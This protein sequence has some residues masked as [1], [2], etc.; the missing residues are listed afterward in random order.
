MPEGFRRM[1][2]LVFVLVF[3]A[4]AASGPA[5]AQE[6]SADHRR[7][8]EEEV[9]YIVTERER[10]VFLTL[11]TTDERDRFIEA[12]WRKRDPIPGT[13]ANEFREEHYRRLEHANRELR[14]EAFSPGWRTDRGRMH[15]VLGPP[16]SIE[17]F[18][19]YNQL[20]TSQLWFYHGDPQRNLPSFFYL[21]F[22]KRQDAVQYRL[23]IPGADVPGDLLRGPARSFPEQNMEQ[24]VRIS[25]ELARAALA[26]DASEAVDI[27]GGA[28]GLGSDAAIARIEASPKFA[29]RTDYLDAWE[30]YGRRVSSE[31]SF[32]FVPSTSSFAVLSGPDGASYLHLSLEL[33]LEDLPMD[34]S[35]DGSRWFTT[36]DAS[37]EVRDREGRLI[38]TDEREAFVQLATAQLD[39][40]RGSTF[41]YQD[42]VPLAPGDYEVML[43]LRN[44]VSR[45]YTVAE[46]PVRVGDSPRGQPAL[47]DVV[48]GFRTEA[49]PDG[50]GAFK[51]FQAGATRV[52]PAAS[53]AFASSETVYCVFQVLSGDP[54]HELRFAVLRGDEVVAERVRPVPGAEPSLIEEPFSLEGVAA[55]RYELRV[56]L[57]D[58]GGRVL[59]E[60]SAPFSV[61]PRASIPR[62]GLFARRSFDATRRALVAVV[63]GDQHWAMEDFAAAE[64]LFER[65]VAEADPEVPEA[66]WKLA[67]SYLRSGRPESALR[68][69]LPLQFEHGD[70][71]EVVVGLGLGFYLRG[72]LKAAVP[73]LAKAVSLRPPQPGVLN[74]LGDAYARLG[75]RARAREVFERS[76][77]IDPEQPDIRE[78]LAEPDPANPP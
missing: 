3:A 25:P 15:I 54:S 75:D 40:I 26:V 52:H 57:Q 1:E 28:V 47:S 66:Q 61:S 6:L 5:P 7:W 14:G 38:L 67:G 36:L 13:P 58:V 10:D 73:H 27:M 21:L 56:R 29:V 45:Q 62:A 77:A 23:F 31:Y 43:I 34:T 65:A 63:L 4:V 37:L 74:A 76:I 50:P 53:G 55:D 44:R 68:L 20:Y 59:A 42:G 64:R 78:R 71:Y 30:R 16:R 32:N 18:D 9:T 22:F 33:D 49:M 39:A 19:N 72:N 51:T 46:H 11:G 12:F 8:I 24:L 35:R 48:L 17:T 2:R 60:K 69:L 70:R 41:A